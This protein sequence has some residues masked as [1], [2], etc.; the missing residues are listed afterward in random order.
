MVRYARFAQKG[1]AYRCLSSPEHARSRRLTRITH[2]IVYTT[3]SF[4]WSHK[5]VQGFEVWLT[6]CCESWGRILV[7]LRSVI[8]FSFRC[9]RCSDFYGNLGFAT[10]W[11]GP[12]LPSTRLQCD[13]A[14]LLP[15][16]SLFLLLLRLRVHHFTSPI[17]IV[18]NVGS[19]K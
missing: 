18:V 11:R 19:L 12:R 2:T 16:H 8:W 4:A 9:D 5:E 3:I 7:C 15:G 14:L 13:W 10:T 6:E 17:S 1:V